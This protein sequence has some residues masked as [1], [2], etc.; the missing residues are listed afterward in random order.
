MATLSNSDTPSDEALLSAARGGSR[1]ALGLLMQSCRTYLLVVGQRE[2]STDLRVK[3][4]PSDLV[5]ETFVEGQ[6]AIRRF[7]GNTPGEFQAWLRAILLNKLANARRRY[8]TAGSR[9]LSREERPSGNSS[10]IAPAELL[11]DDGTPCEHA[12]RQEEAQQVHA[13]LADLP[14]HYRQVI[15]FRNFDLLPFAEIANVMHRS[16]HELRALWVR[17]MQHLKRKLDGLDDR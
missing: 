15:Q 9:D 16:E 11:A 1:E 4:S 6:R 12:I 7:E 17:A 8:L 2:L 14:V 5:Q 13:A 10:V 3:V